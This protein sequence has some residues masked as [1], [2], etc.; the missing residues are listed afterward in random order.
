MK[1]EDKLK[2]LYQYN[3]D[4]GEILLD[5][6]VKGW[7]CSNGYTYVT[8]RF[9]TKVLAHR[10]AWLLHY[11]EW[12]RGDVDH[13]NRNRSDNR[14]TNLR[15]VSRSTN[16]LNHDTPLLKGIGWDSSRNRW[17]VK[18]GRKGFQKRFKNFC[19]A[20]AYRKETLESLHVD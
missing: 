12:P 14:I 19:E 13:I 18:T 5:G 7:V 3:A 15:D 10:L 9:G 20:Y 6:D 17:R 4:T 8:T 11:G 2:A 16:L 1:Y